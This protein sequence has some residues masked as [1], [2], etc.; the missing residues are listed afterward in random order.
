MQLAAII[1][2]IAIPRVPLRN[3][4]AGCKRC[5]AI[6]WL[7]VVYRLVGVQSGDQQCWAKDLSSLLA[8]SVVSALFLPMLLLLQVHLPKPWGRKGI[9]PALAF[10]NPYFV[11]DQYRLAGHSRHTAHCGVGVPA[12]T[13][14]RPAADATR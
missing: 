2:L 13:G 5:R 3:C 10:N 6:G 12:R 11:C 14:A 7:S 8:F 9:T 1:A 4:M